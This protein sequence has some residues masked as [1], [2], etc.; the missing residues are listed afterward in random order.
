MKAESIIGTVQNALLDTSGQFWSETELLS[1]INDAQRQI[2]NYI[3]EANAKI[4]MV[5]LDP[6]V[7]QMLPEDATSLIDV[8][9]NESGN[10]ISA[11]DR[12]DM[13][14]MVPNWSNATASADIE[15]FMYD[16][17]SPSTYLVY[18]P[19]NGSAR[20]E[21]AY[22]ATVKD[23][24]STQSELTLDIRHRSAIIEYVMFRAHSKS[25]KASIPERATAHY[26]LFMNIITG[27]KQ[28][29][30]SQSAG[31]PDENNPRELR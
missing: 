30:M 5:D 10:S 28:G 9:R 21:I 6:G 26:Q 15:H 12:R 3:P 22:S 14:R 25:T 29:D 23:A 7:R 8:I 27:G 11:V 1:Y 20:V 31:R 4:E 16:D 17:R 18:P 24:A 13:D 19:A 2:V